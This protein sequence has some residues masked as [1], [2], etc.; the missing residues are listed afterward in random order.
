MGGGSADLY[1]TV[2]NMKA[3]SGRVAFNYF[4]SRKE[5]VLYDLVFTTTGASNRSSLRF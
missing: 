4:Q 5:D 3:A 1:Y 2:N